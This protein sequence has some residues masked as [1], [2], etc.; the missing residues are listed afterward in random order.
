MHAIGD[1]KPALRLC[2]NEAWSRPSYDAP[3]T[4]TGDVYAYVGG[5][6]WYVGT[7]GV[8]VGADTETV[9]GGE[10]VTA[11]GGKVGGESALAAPLD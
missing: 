9:V 8:V 1:V 7:T 5:V 6:Y 2:R 10:V 3:D 4:T 11:V